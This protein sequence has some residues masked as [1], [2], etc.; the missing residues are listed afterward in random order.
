MEILLAYGADPYAKMLWNDNYP[1]KESKVPRKRKSAFEVLLKRNPGAAELILNQGVQKYSD[2]DSPELVVVYDFTIF[3]EEC[4]AKLPYGD[5][6]VPIDE[7][8]VHNKVVN[9]GQR[10]LLKHPLMAVF[11]HIK[12]HFM[13]KMFYINLIMY[14]LFLGC[15]TSLA[16]LQTAMTDC[17]QVLL[18]I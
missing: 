1:E 18:K 4:T 17:D 14:L 16:G 7:M 2:L 9:T 3:C 11:L 13:Q 6:D 15:L 10:H 12:W 5:E 8:V